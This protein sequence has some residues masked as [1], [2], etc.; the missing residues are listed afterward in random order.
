MGAPSPILSSL[1]LALALTGAAR[2][3]S[4]PPIDGTIGQVL[5][6]TASARADVTERFACH[7]PAGQTFN[8]TAVLLDRNGFDLL[9]PTEPSFFRWRAGGEE[10]TSR[11]FVGAS[12]FRVTLQFVDKKIARVSAQYFSARR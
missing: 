4:C 12:E 2:A 8:E 6:E 11:R 3:Q 10:F 5:A 1:A 9:N 7:F